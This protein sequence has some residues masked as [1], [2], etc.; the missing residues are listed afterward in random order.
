VV[1]KKT[2][3]DNEKIKTPLA[4]IDGVVYSPPQAGEQ[5]TIKQQCPPLG[6]GCFFMHESILRAI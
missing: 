1:R 2:T 3:A 5:N 4:I 6:G